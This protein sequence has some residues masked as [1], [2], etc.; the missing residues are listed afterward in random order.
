M[1]DKDVWHAAVGTLPEVLGRADLPKLNEGLRYLFKDLRNAQ[2]EFVG[3]RHPDGVYLALVAI[4]AFVSLFRAV[5]T[6]GLMAP[7]MELEN[8]LW[9]LDEGIV[10]PL[11]KPARRAK[12]G[13]PRTSQLRQEFLG[14]VAYTV[15]QLREFGYSLP[16]AHSAVADDLNRVGA[17]PDRGSGRFTPR[18]VRDWCERVAEDVGCH[19][20]AAQKYAALSA[21]PRSATIR[22]KPPEAAARLVRQQLVRS[23]VLLGIAPRPRKPT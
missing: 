18:T 12:A 5:T 6:E 19:L 13:R 20:P 10:E 3:G 15:Q 22:Q 1:D 14:A 23:A 4:Y 21:D 7:L 2:A 11:L 9:A 8:A 16:E 17:K